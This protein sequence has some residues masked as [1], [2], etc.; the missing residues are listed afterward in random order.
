MEVLLQF[1]QATLAVNISLY[2]LIRLHSLLLLSAL[3]SHPQLFHTLVSY[4]GIFHEKHLCDF[5]LQGL[6]YFCQR[7]VAHDFI[8]EMLLEEFLLCLRQA[9]PLSLLVDLL[10]LYKFLLKFMLF[11]VFELL[12]L[13]LEG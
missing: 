8:V 6:L 9:L 11:F 12:E 13:K 7:R 10:Q 2:H 5:S 4:R 1:L 3:Q